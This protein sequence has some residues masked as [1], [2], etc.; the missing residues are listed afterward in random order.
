MTTNKVSDIMTT[1]HCI[2]EANVYGV[3]VPGNVAIF[4]LFYANI[5]QAKSVNSLA[6]FSFLSYFESKSLLLF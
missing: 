6:I 2:Q 3:Q 5:D 4:K 1:V